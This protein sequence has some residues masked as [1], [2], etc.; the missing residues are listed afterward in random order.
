MAPSVLTSSFD[1]SFRATVRNFEYVRT[2]LDILFQSLLGAVASGPDPSEADTPEPFGYALVRQSVTK[3]KRL[4]SMM[5]DTNIESLAKSLAEADAA[6]G[7]T[8]HPP[9]RSGSGSRRG[10]LS[11]RRRSSAYRRDSIGGGRGERRNGYPSEVPDDRAQQHRTKKQFYQPG[12]QRLLEEQSES[13]SMSESEASDEFEVAEG[14]EGKE[15]G[16]GEG[17][18]EVAPIAVELVDAECQTDPLPTPPSIPPSRSSSR[19]MLGSLGSRVGFQSGSTSQVSSRPSS[20]GG[21]SVPT[22][23]GGTLRTARQLEREYR[24]PS[25][26]AEDVT[27]L[28]SSEDQDSDIEEVGSESDWLEAGPGV[29]LGEGDVYAEKG[30]EPKGRRGHRDSLGDSRK[31]VGGLTTDGDN[32]SDSGSDSPSDEDSDTD[33]SDA[34]EPEGE[35]GHPPSR[36]VSLGDVLKGPTPS[37]SMARLNSGSGSLSRPGSA[38]KIGA[39]RKSKRGALGSGIPDFS[40]GSTGRLS[41]PGSGL[42]SPSPASS[43]AM[44]RSTSLKGLPQE[45]VQRQMSKPD[46]VSVDITQKRPGSRGG[47]GPRKKSPTKA[48]PAR[49]VK[50]KKKAG[51]GQF[52]YGL[53]SSQDQEESESM[54]VSVEDSEGEKERQRVRQALVDQQS[55]LGQNTSVAVRNGDVE[56]L[57]DLLDTHADDPEHSVTVQRG[58]CLQM[59]VEL[60]KYP[61]LR[62]HAAMMQESSRMLGPSGIVGTLVSRVDTM[63][64]KVDSLTALVRRLMSSRVGVVANEKG[65]VVS[66]A[67][68]VTNVPYRDDETRRPSSSDKNTRGGERGMTSNRRSSVSIAQI[69]R[70]HS[71]LRPTSRDGSSGSL[72]MAPRVTLEDKG[73]DREGSRYGGRGVMPNS[74]IPYLDSPR[75][76]GGMTPRGGGGMTPR[77]RGRDMSAYGQAPGSGIKSIGSVVNLQAPAGDF[78]APSTDPH[79][80]SLLDLQGQMMAGRGRGRRQ[81]PSPSLSSA[82]HTSH[83][84]LSARHSSSFQV[85]PPDSSGSTPNTTTNTTSGLQRSLSLLGL[86]DSED[87]GEA[88]IREAQRQN[89]ARRRERERSVAGLDGLDHSVSLEDLTLHTGPSKTSVPSSIPRLALGGL[90]SLGAKLAVPQSGMSSQVS[91]P[92]SSRGK[93]RERTRDRPGAAGLMPPGS[94]RGSRVPMSARGRRSPMT[95]RGRGRGGMS[96]RVPQTARG[97]SP[98][99]PNAPR[100]P[101]AKLS[102]ASIRMPEAAPYSLQQDVL[103]AREGSKMRL[104]TGW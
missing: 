16:E 65:S 89:I 21:M 96:P 87:D 44:S 2:Q 19:L 8:P 43:P 40:T 77:G 59:A 35:G 64:G 94:A 104:S 3:L 92:M 62:E 61:A 57:Q 38:K 28:E 84:P 56:M 75:G 13:A 6:N 24:P 18:G 54:E 37:G 14:E 72:S 1:D 70:N 55:L 45:G 82:S 32:L 91:N 81:V 34:S 33:A 71:R 73:V 98:G 7:V 100:L 46:G 48:S 11:G 36:G 10:S 50:K 39:R 99:A 51:E 83:T 95:A 15:E 60:S 67:P 30:R 80:A 53:D 97:P 20:R 41:R 27:G 52:D 42:Q 12:L 58:V 74:S 31:S 47:K 88:E 23:A 79:M 78:F 86:A 85:H 29:R 9:G 93:K 26:L 90:A 66:I 101:H 69:A 102:S 68:G 22:S 25:V 63:Q 49:K 4:S 103:T 5:H 76:G 17:E